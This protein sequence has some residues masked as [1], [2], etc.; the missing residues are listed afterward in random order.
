MTGNSTE[1]VELSCDV[2]EAADTKQDKRPILF[3]HG[4][5]WNKYM[6]KDIAEAMC[7]ITKRKV[8]V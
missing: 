2:Y 1:T 5:L 7:N 3:L 6:L 8:N 4:F